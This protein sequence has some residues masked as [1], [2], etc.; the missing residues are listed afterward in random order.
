M[1]KLQTE[2]IEHIIL[3]NNPNIPKGH[4][5]YLGIY[6]QALMEYMSQMSE[7]EIQEMQETQEHWQAE[8]PPIDICLK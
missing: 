7:E 8:G 4:K 6:Q 1:G 3:T 2:D 5:S